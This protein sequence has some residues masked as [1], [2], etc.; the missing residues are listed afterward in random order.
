MDKLDK[1]IKGLLESIS[2][3]LDNAEPINDDG[4]KVTITL[5]KSLADD[6]SKDFKAAIKA[7]G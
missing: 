2:T 1:A 5:S 3:S 6:L 7:I 4:S